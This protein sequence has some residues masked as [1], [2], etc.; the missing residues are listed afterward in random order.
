M[1]HDYEVIVIG[2]GGAGLSAACAAAELG[3][4]VALLEAGTTVGG[5]PPYP[6]AF[7]TRREQACK[8]KRVL[9]T[10]LLM[11]CMNIT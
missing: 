10:T 7:S 11:I 5:Q 2:G 3:A 6:V 9:K 8:N 1:E 4:S